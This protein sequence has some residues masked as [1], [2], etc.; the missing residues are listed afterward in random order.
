[1]PA[2]PVRTFDLRAASPGDA[3]TLLTHAVAPRPVAWVSTVSAADEPN[4]A[5][6]SYFNAGGQ[7]PPSVVFVPNTDPE[8]G[9]KDT[10][11]NIR[12]T[13]EYVINIARPEQAR[14][15][16]AT[17]AGLSHGRSEWDAAGLSPVPSQVVKPGRVPGCPFALECRLHTIVPHGDG[18]G[19]ANY[20]IGEVL[21]VHVAADL[22]NDAGEVGSLDSA[23][24][25]GLGRLGGDWYTDSRGDA[26]FRLDRPG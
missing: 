4:L 16:N 24:C 14:D 1:M 7:N 21:L 6:Y 13:G 18:P 10:L 19:A 15:M 9:E 25:G 12:E 8:K 5:P 26:L 17:A 2:P 11:R 3:Y 20:V 22:L 23:T